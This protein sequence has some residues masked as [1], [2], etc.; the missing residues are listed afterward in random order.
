MLTSAPLHP[1][2]GGKWTDGR[3]A[4]ERRHLKHRSRRSRCSGCRH[5][6]A[7]NVSHGAADQRVHATT[8][9]D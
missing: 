3:S 9:A 1:D 2:A 6:K 4:R 5:G 8:K 7:L